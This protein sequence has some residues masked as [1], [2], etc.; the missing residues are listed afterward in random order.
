MEITPI[1]TIF[2]DYTDKF[3]VP[4]QSG[5]A[6]IES[7]ITLEAPY[8][9]ENA[10]RGI[11]GYSHLWLIWGFSKNLQKEHPLTVRPPRLGG[12]IRMGVFAT[13]S[14]FRPNHLG[15]SSVRLER[16]EYDEQRH[17]M[18]IVS[19]ADL[20]SGTPIY[21]IKPYIRFTDSHEDAVSGIADSVPF[22]RLEVVI[23]EALE[24]K[25]PAEKREA[26][27]AIL[28]DDPR[29]AYQQDNERQYGFSFA[30]NEIQFKVEGNTLTVTNIL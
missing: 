10:V 1:A 25:I 7:R 22:H 11:E 15:L 27:R 6:A 5:I 17:P 18:L 16:I 2:N 26:L 8:N 12:N 29:P 9:D 19:G 28:T 20:I 21:D 30:N 14:P 3:A 13:R 24:A 4:R 23:P